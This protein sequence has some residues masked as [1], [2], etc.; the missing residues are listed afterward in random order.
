MI[1][2]GGEIMSDNKI[3]EI[4]KSVFINICEEKYS[5]DAI[6]SMLSKHSNGNKISA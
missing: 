2:K 6:K 3:K 5:E 4:C 1:A